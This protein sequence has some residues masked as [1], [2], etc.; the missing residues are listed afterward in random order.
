MALSGIDSS[1]RTA[2]DMLSVKTFSEVIALNAGLTCTSLDTLVGGS[3]EAFGARREARRRSRSVD[4]GQLG[5]SW[6]LPQP[7]RRLS[8]STLARNARICR[9]MNSV[10]GVPGAGRAARWPRSDGISA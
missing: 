2:S 1:A 5:K 9:S 4:A 6:L 8:Y 7:D 10:S 3:V